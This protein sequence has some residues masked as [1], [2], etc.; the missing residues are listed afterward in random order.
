MMMKLI[1]GQILV[2][3]SAIMKMKLFP[4]ILRSQDDLDDLL[5]TKQGIKVLKITIL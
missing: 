3:I 4:S 5:G 1:E 2:I